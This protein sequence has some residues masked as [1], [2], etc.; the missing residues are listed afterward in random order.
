M[1]NYKADVDELY[2]LIKESYLYKR[3]LDIESQVDDNEDI[4]LLVNE[5]KK[6]QKQAVNEEYKREH[7]KLKEIEETLESK[8]SELNNIPLYAEY[9]KVSEQ[10]NELINNIKKEMQICID[11]IT[12]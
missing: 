11:D 7:N 1:N 8:K 2:N 10:I 4:N 3:Y 6:L 12:S 9:I 5:I